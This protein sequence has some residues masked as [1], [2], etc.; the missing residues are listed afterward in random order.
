MMTL[1]ELSE[2]ISTATGPGNVL[3]TQIYRFLNSDPVAEGSI[4]PYTSDLAFAFKL[5]ELAPGLALLMLKHPNGMWSMAASDDGVP[6]LDG[7]MFE[8]QYLALSIV[9][10]V[11][12]TLVDR[13]A[14]QQ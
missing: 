2:R 1:Q 4:P 12:E 10:T 13:G 7:S 14:R 9:A 8:E 6:Q 5:I 3:D 11:F